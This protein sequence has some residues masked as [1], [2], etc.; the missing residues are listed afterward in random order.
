MK[1][2]RKYGN[3]SLVEVLHYDEKRL[4]LVQG[5]R[6]HK[7]GDDDKEQWYYNGVVLRIVKSEKSY[8]HSIL[9]T[10]V[11]Y[12]TTVINV[13]EK[14]IVEHISVIDKEFNLD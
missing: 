7:C 8:W 3:G 2:E 9:N 5:A 12:C 1:P 14:S 10:A 13:P 6:Y 4:F 11:R